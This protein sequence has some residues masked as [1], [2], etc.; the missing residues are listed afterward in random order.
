MAVEEDILDA[1]V[2]VVTALGLSGATV[3]KR[4]LPARAEGDTLPLVCVACWEDRYEPA[5]ADADAAWFGYYR[6]A[7]TVL[8][9][10]GMKLADGSTDRD[11]REDIRRAVTGPSLVAAGADLVDDCDPD[12]R[13]P[14]DPAMLDRNYN[15]STAAFVVRT[16][17]PR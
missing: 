9:S 3:V 12:G 16:L 17:E 15:F 13:P 2:A 5:T 14:F 8:T 7:A 6:L 1:G 11:W 10:S 4:K